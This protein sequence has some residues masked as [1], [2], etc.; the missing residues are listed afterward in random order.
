[1]KLIS[2]YIENFGAIAKKQIGFDERLTSV[3]EE[4]GCGKTTLAAFLEAMFYG[5]DSDRANSREF[6]ARRHFYP[7]TGGRF[8]G[9][10]VFSAGGDVYKIERYFDEKSESKDS[11]TVYKNNE[12]QAGSD[13]Q[14]GEKIFG[15]DKPSFERTIFIDAREIE[16]ASTGSINAKLNRFLEGGTDET[17][18]ENALL[19]LEKT[20][21]EY[22]K[23]R[24]GNDLITQENDRLLELNEKIANFE[25]IKASLPEKYRRLAEYD[26]EL[27][28]LQKSLDGRQKAALLQKDWEQYDAYLSAAAASEKTMRE[29]DEKYPFGIP[30]SAEIGAVKK[31][32][33]AR[34][35]LKGQAVRPLSEEDAAALSSMRRKYAE[36]VP[37]ETELAELAEKINA[38]SAAETELKLEENAESAEYENSLRE[39]FAAGVPDDG[40]I[41]AIDAAVA[42]ADRAE[43]EYALIPDYVI[44][45]GGQTH[46]DKSVSGKK[47]YLAATIVS[48]LTAAAGI[49]TIFFSLV[50]G[51][52][53]LAAGVLGL[54]GTGFVY[55]NKKTA[56]LPSFE[57]VQKLNP[58]KIA[59]EREKNA[60]AFRARQLLAR[61]GYSA[62]Q[63]ARY[64]AEKLKSELAAYRKLSA[65]D[66][67]KSERLAKKRKDCDRLREGLYAYFAE[68]GFTGGNLRG[69]FSDLQREINRYV[70]LAQMQ[71]KVQEQNAN[72]KK[73]IETQEQ[74]IAD[75]CAAYRFPA[76]SIETEIGRIER[77]AAA[78]AQACRDRLSY[79]E[80]AEKFKTEKHLET[81]PPAEDAAETEEIKARMAQLGKDRS[82]LGIDIA[83]CETDAE[84]LDD[85]YAE[86]QR[87]AELLKE[88]KKNYNILM[89]TAELLQKADKRL[90][91]KYVAP[92]KDRFVTYAAL[93]EEA[94]GEKVVMTPNFEI[95]YERDGTERSEKHLSAG[96]RSICAFCFRM[97]LVENMYAGEKPFLILDDPFSSLDQKHLDKVKAMLKKL[98]ER[99]Q[100]IYF[101]CHESRAV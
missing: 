34:E 54:I 88:Y 81:R 43:K 35:A 57:A 94:I 24:A 74:A 85:L 26:S 17:N 53:L 32:L 62:E 56:A 22:K 61:Y 55:L 27:Q 14:I 98:S 45:R 96:Q 3:C 79:E 92:V 76:A 69:M 37:A 1:M 89:R 44:E 87:H 84:R 90:K 9:N 12:L 15:I 38:L 6:G 73:T 75:F 28:A 13:G 82:T 66:R 48:A 21:K 101:T 95:R 80:R 72:F 42:D 63:D 51:A 29:T 99:L 65:A 39:K 70:S 59:K 7:F 50:A 11:V 60:A 86:E 52:V 68:Y 36:G 71:K 83:E 2:C 93:L 33:S 64:S 4:N 46:A 30:S 10:V 67:E 78:Y 20:A 100:I 58:E 77:D 5:M 31:A 25:N 41:A 40:E 16:I 19:R 91:D 49:A 97:A 23:S 18:A 8:G 47:K